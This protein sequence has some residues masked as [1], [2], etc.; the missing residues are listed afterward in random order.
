[1][2]D[3][4]ITIQDDGVTPA[5]GMIIAGNNPPVNFDYAQLTPAQKATYDAFVAMVKTL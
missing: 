1:M 2:F 5:N 3:Y 4:R